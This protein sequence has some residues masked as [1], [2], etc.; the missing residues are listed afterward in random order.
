ML[1]VTL[2][3]VI[4]FV[5]YGYG[6]MKILYHITVVAITNII[7]YVIIYNNVVTMM[8]RMECKMRFSPHFGHIVCKNR[9]FAARLS[10]LNSALSGPHID[11]RV[12]DCWNA[13]LKTSFPCT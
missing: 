3:N 12:H 8:I 6:H 10:S 9:G 13:S 5:Q 1:V 2:I 4:L 11:A 7:Y